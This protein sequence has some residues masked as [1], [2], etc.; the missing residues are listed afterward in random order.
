SRR[1][2]I[3]RAGDVHFI[4]LNRTR[5]QKVEPLTLGN[6]LDDVHQHHIAKLLLR[7]SQCAIRADV[8]SANDR[9]LL[10]HRNTTVGQACRPGQGNVGAINY[11]SSVASAGQ[12]H[13]EALSKPWTAS[14]VLNSSTLLSQAGNSMVTREATCH[15]C[16]L[17][18]KLANERVSSR[19]SRCF[20]SVVMR[21]ET[22]SPSRP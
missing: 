21:S 5:L 17:I 1:R 18:G 8:T 15:S 19:S 20:A 3:V 13:S 22:R 4:A 10:S 2:V 9:D 16:G 11:A 6:A 12:T 7:N 14:S